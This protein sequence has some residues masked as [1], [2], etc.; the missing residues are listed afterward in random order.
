M[1]A[2]FRLVVHAA[3][4]D[5]LEFAAHRAGDRLAERGLADAGGADEAEDRRLT[6][7]L[8]LAHGEV[9]DDAPLDLVQIVMVLVEDAPRF[10]DVDRL[11]LGQGPG[12]LDQPI[13]IGAHYAVFASG[14]GH[15]LQATQLL[16]RLIFHFLRHAGIADGLIELGDLRGLAFLALAKLALNCRHLLAK[17]HLALTL[18][19]RRLGLAADLLRQP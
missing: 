7:R 15:A 18:V 10:D 11:L 9:F 19:E 13:Q 3:Q 4:A 8:Q 12:K 1:A 2:Q 17:Q 16:A 14:F 5:A 6:L